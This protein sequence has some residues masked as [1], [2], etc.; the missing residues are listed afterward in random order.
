MIMTHSNTSL[1]LS[2]AAV[3]LLGASALSLPAFA[4]YQGNEYSVTN[5]AKGSPFVTASEPS[6]RGGQAIFAETRPFG[7]MVP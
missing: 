7:K 5:G 1:K 6:T 3:V 4:A 2:L